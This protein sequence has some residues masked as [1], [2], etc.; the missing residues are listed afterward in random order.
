[1]SQYKSMGQNIKDELSLRTVDKF[2]V[3]AS[4]EHEGEVGT[5]KTV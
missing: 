1:M 3:C 4:G 5:V 2:L